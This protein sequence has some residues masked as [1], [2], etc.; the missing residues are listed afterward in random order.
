MQPVHKKNIKLIFFLFNFI[1]VQANAQSPEKDLSKS[2]FKASLSYLSD[3]VYNGRKDSIAYPYI[4]PTVG[5]YHKTG[6]Y[7]N[8]SL[9]YLAAT[10]E[11]RIDLFTLEVGYDFDI[12][13]KLSG[14]VYADKYFYNTASTNVQSDIKGVAGASF[15]Y[16]FGVLQ[17]SAGAGV[18]FATKKDI[19]LTASIDHPFTIGDVGNQWTISPTVSVNASTLH[20]YEGYT[21]RRIGKK[22]G[23]ANANAGSVTSVT[24]ITN[25]STGLTLL[26]YE[27]ALTIS[28]DADIWGF[29]F[30]PTLALPQN[31][32]FT[33]TTTT[34]KPRIGNNTFKQT[35]DSTPS[36]ERNLGT[37]FF[38]EI[39]VYF[40]F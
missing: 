38:A 39:S 19:S 23:N 1:V 21:E 17:L 36:S 5:Y 13:N 18:L 9:S 15:S 12:T 14:G 31:S 35:S 11:K 3:A 34:F 24:T 4:T 37:P 32:I 10:S 40:K 16:D 30:T 25:R 7:A 22:A 26:D 6:V 20:F 27:L 2:Y 28:Y 29:S 33:S 8:G